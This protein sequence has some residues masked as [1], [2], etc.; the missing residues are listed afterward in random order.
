MFHVNYGL[1]KLTLGATVEKPKKS[2]LVLELEKY[3]LMDAYELFRNHSIT[4]DILWTL[5]ENEIKEIGLNLG[6]RRRYLL[7]VEARKEENHEAGK[8][9]NQGNFH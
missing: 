1:I 9:E 5:S 2:K 7:A 3:N 8:E 4:H 6:Q